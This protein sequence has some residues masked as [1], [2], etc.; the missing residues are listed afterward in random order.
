MFIVKVDNNNYEGMSGIKYSK[1]AVKNAI[2]R[3]IFENGYV[4]KGSF[5]FEKAMCIL[6]NNNT[7][8]LSSYDRYYTV[9]GKKFIIKDNAERYKK[10]NNLDCEIKEITQENI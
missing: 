3:Q 5:D 7:F 10:K 2:C 6:F 1:Q 8:E 9:N 4:I